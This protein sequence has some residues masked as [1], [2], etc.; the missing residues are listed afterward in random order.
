[1][2]LKKIILTLL[3]VLIIIFSSVVFSSESSTQEEL[4]QSMVFDQAC[5]IMHSEGR[6]YLENKERIAQSYGASALI[7]QHLESQL[8]EYTQITGDEIEGVRKIVFEKGVILFKEL[9]E[10]QPRELVNQCRGLVETIV[11][12]KI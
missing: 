3:S 9:S 4:Q 2:Q 7:E 10:H 1:M 6:K 11:R 5:I 8:G 12:A